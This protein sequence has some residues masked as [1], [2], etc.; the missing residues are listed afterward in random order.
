MTYILHC[1]I[2]FICMCRYR[3][4]CYINPNFYGFSASAVLLLSNFESDCERR[5]GSELECYTSSGQ[6]VLDRFSFGDINPY[7][8]IVVSIIC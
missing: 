4:L 7:Q 6:Y 3:W 1:V 2:H 5:G 8:N